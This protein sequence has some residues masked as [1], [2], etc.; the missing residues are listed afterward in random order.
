[1]IIKIYRDGQLCEIDFEGKRPLANDL[2]KIF[3]LAIEHTSEV[4]MSKKDIV[5]CFEKALKEVG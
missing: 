1:M 3:E 5:E 2:R 4:D